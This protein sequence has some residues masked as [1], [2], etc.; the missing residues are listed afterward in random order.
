MF[1]ALLHHIS[2]YTSIGDCGQSV[3]LENRRFVHPHRPRRMLMG[4]RGGYVMAGDVCVI[5]S[6]PSG[7]SVINLANQT[8]PDINYS[9]LIVRPVQLE[10][11]FQIHTIFYTSQVLFTLPDIREIPAITY[12][13]FCRPIYANQ[14]RIGFLLCENRGENG[15]RDH[16]P[17]VL[18]TQNTLFLSIGVHYTNE[19]KF[20]TI[21][22]HT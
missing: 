4:R 9:N 20:K 22:I 11:H 14:H 8:N 13:C 1:R 18:L 12:I 5:C 10:Q 3:Q 7:S 6:A 21:Y 15:A 16:G 19:L 17:T 2:Q